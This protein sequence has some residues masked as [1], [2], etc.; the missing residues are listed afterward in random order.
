[1]MIICGII[2]MFIISTIILIF[3][4]GYNL[5]IRKKRNIYNMI[6]D[7]KEENINAFSKIGLEYKIK[8]I[9]YFL[10][11][12]ITICLGLFSTVGEY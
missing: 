12:I 8:F 5:Y 1:M 7:D 10:V 4:F 3:I 11:L 6:I 9:L 2:S